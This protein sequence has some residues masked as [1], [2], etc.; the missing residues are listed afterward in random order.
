MGY[1]WTLISQDYLQLGCGVSDNLVKAAAVC[2]PRL[3]SDF[4][5]QNPLSMLLQL[6]QAVGERG[7]CW[8]CVSAPGQSR[9]SVLSPG[10]SGRA[11]TL[12]AG[13]GHCCC[14][15]CL[16]WGIFLFFLVVSCGQP[17]LLS[18]L[19]R[20]CHHSC[21]SVNASLCLAVLSREKPKSQVQV[22]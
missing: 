13:A 5:E 18:D 21:F 1:F 12:S 17:K 19:I 11:V 6:L 8:V 15:F 14:H 20:M 2:L 4:G 22:M 9:S 16:G 3:V 7:Q 10:P